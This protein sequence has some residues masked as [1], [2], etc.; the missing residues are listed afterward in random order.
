MKFV[1]M[2]M[3]NGKVMVRYIR[4]SYKLSPYMGLNELAIELDELS[5]TIAKSIT[6]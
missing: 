2:E 1:V 6:N 4:P 5:A 3:P